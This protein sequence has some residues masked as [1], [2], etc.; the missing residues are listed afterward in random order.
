MKINIDLKNSLKR[1]YKF[2]FAKP[3]DKNVVEVTIPKEVLEREAR[4]RGIS[5]EDFVRKY[6][7]EWNFNSFHGLYLTFVEKGK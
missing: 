2:R 1:K 4:K 5:L 6:E 7:A 3:P